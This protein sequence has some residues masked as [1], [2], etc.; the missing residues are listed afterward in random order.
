[1]VI[2]ARRGKGRSRRPEEVEEEE[3]EFGLAGASSNPAG[4]SCDATTPKGFKYQSKSTGGIGLLPMESSVPV[5]GP[6]R[7]WGPSALP[8]AR[9]TSRAL[10]R[11]AL[12][13]PASYAWIAVDSASRP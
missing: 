13:R 11:E 10:W 7:A 5:L 12:R 4:A 1:M 6:L 3:M 8:L 2:M 9:R